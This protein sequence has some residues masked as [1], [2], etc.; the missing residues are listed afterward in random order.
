[1]PNQRDISLKGLMMKRTVLNLI[2]DILAF[3]ALVMLASTGLLM[4]FR[5]PAGSGQRIEVW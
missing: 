5:L 1:M 2:V 3:A 4:H